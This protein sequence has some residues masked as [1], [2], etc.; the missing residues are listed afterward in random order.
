M[1]FEASRDFQR[2][3]GFSKSR[4]NSG[5]GVGWGVCRIFIYI[6]TASLVAQMVKHLSTMR[7]TW[8]RSLG[9]EDSLEKA[10]AT[11]SITLA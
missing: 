1:T 2:L 5:R 6:Y 11:H 8:V 7:E 3:Q 4:V 9:R 10:T